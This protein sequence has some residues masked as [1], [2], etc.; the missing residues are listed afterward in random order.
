MNRRGFLGSILT[1]CVAPAIVRADRLMR[2]V[3]RDATVLPI[4]INPLDYDVV[5][6]VGPIFRGQLGS[7]G[8]VT[9]RQTVITSNIIE[10]LHRE[11]QAEI[12]RQR[13]ALLD[14]L[15]FVH[16]SDYADLKGHR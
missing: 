1:A 8:G 5:V 4:N 6:D 12:N 14:N 7:Y 11:A 2:V 3:P 9:I 16:P 15:V 13:R 10:R